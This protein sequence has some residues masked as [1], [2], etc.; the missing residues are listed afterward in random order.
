MTV[1]VLGEAEAELQE[2]M[3]YYEDRR[4]GLGV[5]FYE[6]VTETI[7]AIG[8]DPI[9]F[10]MYEGKCLSRP[11]RRALIGRFPYVVVFEVRD[12]ETL[13]VAHTSREPGYWE[14]RG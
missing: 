9:R 5:D 10:P 4:E 13:V 14:Q 11:L 3:L 12:E 2:A 8:S 7:L 1:R 6:R